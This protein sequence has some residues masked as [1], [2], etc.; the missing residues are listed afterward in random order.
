MSTTVTIGI[1]IIKPKPNI[2]VLGLQIDTKLKWRAHI[3]KIQKKMVNQSMALT[4]ISTLT[5]GTT[6]SKAK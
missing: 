3:Q 5:W 2:R 6:F 1:Q 4:K